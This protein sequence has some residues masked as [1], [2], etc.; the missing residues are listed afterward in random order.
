MRRYADIGTLL[1]MDSMSKVSYSQSRC[2]TLSSLSPEW[3]LR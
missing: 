2:S 1:C 3:R